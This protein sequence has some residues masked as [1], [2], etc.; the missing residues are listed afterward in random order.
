MKISEKELAE[1]II[2]EMVKVKGVK[3]TID[4]VTS[5]S[6]V[7]DYSLEVSSTA[8]VQLLE[9]AVTN[10]KAAAK[11]PDVVIQIGNGSNMTFPILAHEITDAPPVGPPASDD[12]ILGL[13]T[14]VFVAIIVGAFL[15]LV[16]G[17]LGLWWKFGRSSGPQQGN[18]A[19][20]RPNGQGGEVK[21]YVAKD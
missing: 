21:V 3:I 19:R 6:T 18:E 10:V 11:N 20:G 12:L 15:L 2:E 14:M 9:T 17:A 16:A 7:I 5:G 8:D 1:K 4:D 13:S